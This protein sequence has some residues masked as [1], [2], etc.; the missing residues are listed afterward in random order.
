MNIPINCPMCGDP[1][2][3]EYD[4]F[5]SQTTG[6]RKSLV[7]LVKSCSKRLNHSYFITLNDKEE[8]FC[9]QLSLRFGTFYW[10]FERKI[11]WA[12]H[13]YK[14]RIDFPWFDPEIIDSKKFTHKLK[15]IV[16]FS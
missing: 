5:V 1:L 6:D 2:L 7:H 3:N 11:C 13:N 14:D 12:T 10:N 8:L 16:T 15:T 9:L 4:K